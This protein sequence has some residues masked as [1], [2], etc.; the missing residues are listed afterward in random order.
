MFG[1]SVVL[2][3]AERETPPPGGAPKDFALPGKHTE[4]LDNGLEI[5]AVQFGIVPKV[6]LSVVVDAGNL[7]EG[8]RTWLADLTGD[9]LLEGTTSRSAEAIAREA[10]A[11]GGQ[12]SVSVGEDQTSIS[13]DVLAEYAPQMATLLADIVRNP[14]FPEGE[15]QR[16]RRDRL[17]QL[18]VAQTQPDQMALA[19]FREALYGEHPYGNLFPDASQ[20][21]SYT[22]ADVRGFY[23]DNFGAARSGVF[24]AGKFDDEATLAAVRAAFSDWTEGPDPLVDVPETA[25]GKVVVDVIDRPDASQSNV[26]LGLP[27]ISPGHDDWIPLQ[28][29]N[30]LLGGFFSSRITSNIRED[31][32]YTYSPFS[33]L[34]TRYKDGYWVQ[35]AAVTTNVT[36]P[37]IEEIFKEIETL[38]SEPPPPA[39]LDGVKNYSAGVFVLQNSTRGGIINVLS[40]LDHHEL[41][42]TYLSNYVSNV[43]A[44]T[45]EQVSGIARQYL[46]EEDMTLVVVGDRSQVSEQVE[47]WMGRSGDDQ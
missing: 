21:E 33:T 3:E 39:E 27:V 6:S 12:V 38:Q 8:E 4:R 34:S 1:S 15:L 13:G 40:Y 31:K 36:G 42:D 37:A 43:F 20:L 46:R 47:P 25:D 32:G 18:S 16:L 19:A 44:V 11:M 30:T 10:A 5:T 23:G 35:V 29:S 7:N 9:F 26:Y 28:V 24:I 17:R 22:I 45:P 41:P 2:A 14:A